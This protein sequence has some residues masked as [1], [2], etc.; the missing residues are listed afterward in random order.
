M[1]RVSENSSTASMKY[2]INRTKSKLEN[3]QLKG[4]TL[5]DVN[6]PSDNPL[7]SVEGLS[8]KS[9]QKDNSQYLRNIGSA[10]LSLN[11]TEASLEQLTDILVKAKEMAIAQA[12][13]FYNPDVRKSVANEVKQLRNQALSI[14]NKRVGQKYIFGG[15]KTTEPPFNDLGAYKGDTG[16]T[17]VEVSKDFFVPINLHG[18]EVFYG[19]NAKS[20]FSTRPSETLPMEQEQ[21]IDDSLPPIPASISRDL[22]SEEESSFLA[23]SNLFAHLEIF[24]TALENND[25]MLIQDLLERF[26]DDIDRLINLRTQVGSL[27]NSIENSRQ[28]IETENVDKSERISKLMDADVAELFSDINKQQA[29]LETTYKST[30]GLMNKKLLDFLR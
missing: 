12:S 9:S 27:V 7:N 15:F 2:A 29:I 30:Q 10:L 19:K 25:P 11:I 26:D 17:S 6:R 3:L 14:A 1:S 20:D 18:Q 16:K 13:D 21:S 5:R 22:A 4:A 23:K 24:A 8:L 28:N